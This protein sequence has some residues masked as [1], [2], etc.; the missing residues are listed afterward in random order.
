[1]SETLSNLAA[2]RTE[3]VSKF[4]TA[5]RQV[6]KALGYSDRVAQARC[7]AAIDWLFG[8]GPL[9]E[10]GLGGHARPWA[11]ASAEATIDEFV[12]VLLSGVAGPIKALLSRDFERAFA[13]W[14]RRKCVETPPFRLVPRRLVAV[15]GFRSRRL[16]FEVAAERRAQHT[17]LLTPAAALEL[18]H[19]Q[20]GAAV[21]A[22]TA[23]VNRFIST[24]TKRPALA[25]A[26]TQGS[27]RAVSGERPS[28]KRGRGLPH[29]GSGST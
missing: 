12:E 8:T 6:A 10:L 4:A 16:R 13:V 28:P 3:T 21:S 20:I 14:C 11:S 17:V 24:S 18:D 26:R 2:S 1:M 27:E 19:R 23:A 25:G 9:V 22:A 7:R 5:F 29:R 15:H